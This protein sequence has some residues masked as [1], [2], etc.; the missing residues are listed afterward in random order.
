MNYDGKYGDCATMN[1]KNPKEYVAYKDD[2]HPSALSQKVWG[3][4]LI[5]T[6]KSLYE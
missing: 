2:D 1:R 4:Y 5:N 3:D 6:V